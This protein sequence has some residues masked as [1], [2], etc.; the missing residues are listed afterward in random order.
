MFIDKINLDTF[1]D[2]MSSAYLPV[3]N[4]PV[5]TPSL[6]QQTEKNLEKSAFQS[7]MKRS[8]H[9]I[10]E[11]QQRETKENKIENTSKEKENDPRDSR[12]N[13]TGKRED[14]TANREKINEKDKNE[15]EKE[16]QSLKQKEKE[17]SEQS[18]ENDQNEK[19]GDPHKVTV[20]K[21]GDTKTQPE[22]TL[23]RFREAIQQNRLKRQDEISQLKIELKDNVK[24]SQTMQQANL[25]KI[26]LKN[27]EDTGKTQ[28]IKSTASD[29]IDSTKT[30][31][32]EERT[33]PLHE[34]D[35]TT[36]EQKKTSES[37]PDKKDENNIIKN[38][39]KLQQN[40]TSSHNPPIPN[41]TSSPKNTVKMED[42]AA[43]QA[44]P[45]LQNPELFLLYKDKIT[46][47]V[48]N[49]I[50][51]MVANNEN[52]VTMQLHPPEL[53]KINVEL[54]VKDHAINAKINT[55][56]L[57][58]REVILNNLDQLK[59]NLESQGIHI[60][61]FDVEVGGFRNQFE[62]QFSQGKSDSGSRRNREHGLEGPG[63]ERNEILPGSIRN[64][65]AVS[66]YLGR[67]I[68]CL[69]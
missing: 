46:S 51:M 32:D 22:N 9:A 15:N 30:K 4:T 5:N 16:K 7:E 57:G 58:V 8:E 28:K 33:K 45:P 34:E 67:S 50:K 66:Y 44:A 27:L 17:A 54:L 25:E 35:K 12:K 52:R 37:K 18:Q 68:N 60:N 40:E 43:K 20:K 48:E 24:D 49:N 53:G 42:T 3:N 19:T 31:T 39:P 69:I 41:S 2:A 59:S 61:K 21:D 38:E 26:M 13:D 29:R 11:I 36:Q 65:A 6:S 14:L 56:N 62:Q 63:S 1:R 55:E 47:S 10:V 23:A 64:Q